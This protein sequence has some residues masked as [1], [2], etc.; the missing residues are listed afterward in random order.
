MGNAAGGRV[1][2]ST[3]FGFGHAVLATPVSDPHG[4]AKQVAETINL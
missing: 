1:W 4:N 3:E 2:E